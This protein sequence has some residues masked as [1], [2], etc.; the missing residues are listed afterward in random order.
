MRS[1][2][3]GLYAIHGTN[4]N[5]GIGLRVGRDAFAC[6]MTILNSCL[7]TYRWGRVQLIDQPVKYTVEPDGSHWL[8]VH[9]PLVAQPGGRES[10]RKVP[11]RTS[12]LR[13]FHSG[14]GGVLRRP[15][16]PC[17]AAPAC[18]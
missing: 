2:S 18:R 16:K 1:T 15:S 6:A 10:D 3:A 5:F 4:A 13:E 9:E 17:S 7:I 8:E 14:A 11:C 12:A